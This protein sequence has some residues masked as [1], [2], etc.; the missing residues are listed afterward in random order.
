MGEHL[1]ELAHR[2]SAGFN[3]RP[4]RHQILKGVG[5]QFAIRLVQPIEERPASGGP[6]RLRQGRGTTHVSLFLSEE[7]QL[8]ALDGGIENAL[9]GLEVRQ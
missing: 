6:V 1:R 8:E 7:H 4:E 9:L 2:M 5:F 3:N